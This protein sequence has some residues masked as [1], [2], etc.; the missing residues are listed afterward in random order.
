M[1]AAIYGVVT[2]MFT[3]GGG[4]TAVVKVDA[5]DN[6]SVSITMPTERLGD[7]RL[8]SRMAVAVSTEII[9]VQPLELGVDTIDG[10]KEA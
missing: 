1:K 10:W 2:S 3:V 8:G 7:V 6:V 4:R 5:G 9:E